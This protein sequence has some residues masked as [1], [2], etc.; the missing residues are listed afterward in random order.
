MVRNI[1]MSLSNSILLL[2]PLA[3]TPAESPPNDDD[4]ASP[5][6]PRGASYEK[7]RRFNNARGDTIL[8]LLSLPIAE[9]VRR[10]NNGRRDGEW[11]GN[12]NGGGEG[13]GAWS[14]SGILTSSTTPTEC[15]A[16]S[17]GVGCCGDGSD[18]SL[19]IVMVLVAECIHALAI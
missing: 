9:M 6:P 1:N 4:G 16:E 11:C 14:F 3:A 2:L 12:E 8:L 17:V 13:R 15:E 7:A 5:S 10:A 18:N 19:F